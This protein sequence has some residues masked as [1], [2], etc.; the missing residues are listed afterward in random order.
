MFRIMR[1]KFAHIDG[2]VK[3]CTLLCANFCSYNK[4][5]IGFVLFSLVH[6]S[7]LAVSR[8]VGFEFIRLSYITNSRSVLNAEYILLY[9]FNTSQRGVHCC[10]WN[11]ED[12]GERLP[13]FLAYHVQVIAFQLKYKNRMVFHTIYLYCMCAVLKWFITEICYLESGGLSERNTC[14]EYLH[15]AANVFESRLRIMTCLLIGPSLLILGPHNARATFTSEFYSTNSYV[16][17]KSGQNLAKFWL[18]AYPIPIQNRN[19]L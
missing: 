4:K 6:D 11:E 9:I 19:L 7:R 18:S 17:K 1:K 10:V 3:L 15:D 2:T 14:L 16:W 13:S 8:Y 5:N 12:Y